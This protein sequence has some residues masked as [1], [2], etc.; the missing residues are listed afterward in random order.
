MFVTNQKDIVAHAKYCYENYPTIVNNIPRDVNKYDNTLLD[1]ARMDNMLAGSQRDIGEAS[2]LAQIAQSYTCNFPDQKYEDYV[3][4]LSVIAQ[5]SI[6]SAKRRFDIDIAEEIRLIKKDMDISAHKYP[7]FWRTIKHGFNLSNINYDL[8]CPMNYLAGLK[9]GY[10]KKSRTIPTS[11]FFERIEFKANRN[12]CRKVE[13]LIEK[14]Q[15]KLGHYNHTDASENDEYF[16]LRSDFQDLVDDIRQT[17][18]S[19]NY[20]SLVS[21]L[22]NRAFFATAG[23]IRNKSRYSYITS[24]NRSLL[25][26]VLYDVNPKLFLSCFKTSINT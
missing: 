14:Y 19:R 9:L 8:K 16:L 13:E 22:L 21:W 7:R 26:K 12:T 4:I 11:E 3:A 20:R 24:K 15:I 23:V 5:A 6:D 2:N 25:L 18:I 1:Y 10:T 17:F